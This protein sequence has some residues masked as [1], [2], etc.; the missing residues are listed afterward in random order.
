[1]AEGSTPIE[2]S[3]RHNTSVSG[4]RARELTGIKPK[5]GFFKKVLRGFRKWDTKSQVMAGAIAAG[6]IVGGIVADKTE[7]KPE[8]TIRDA[9]SSLTANASAVISHGPDSIIDAVSR[10]MEGSNHYRDI[11]GKFLTLDK[12]GNLVVTDK[13][14]VITVSFIPETD[15]TSELANEGKIRIRRSPEVVLGEGEKISPKDIHGSYAVRVAGGA[16]GESG[17]SRFFID[18]NGKNYVIGEW[19]MLTNFEGKPVS[20]DGTLL[21]DGEDKYYVAGNFVKVSEPPP[22]TEPEPAKW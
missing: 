7:M 18:Y 12:N 2:S 13:P 14:D 21:K 17:M 11:Y 4:D 8:T 22:G 15:P 3:I 6:G 5:E 19:L 20:P 16:Y 1:M 9:T 10:Q